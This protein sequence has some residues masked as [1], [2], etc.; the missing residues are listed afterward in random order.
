MTNH[1]TTTAVDSGGGGAGPPTTNHKGNA[2]HHPQATPKM[3]DRKGSVFWIKSV[4][5]E[6]SK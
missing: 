2:E 1:T 6:Y 5:L 4:S 3:R